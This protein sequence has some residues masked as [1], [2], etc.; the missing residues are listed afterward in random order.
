MNPG[1]GCG[2]CEACL[3]GADNLCR[4]YK[5]LGE[6]TDG[7]YAELVSV[8]LRN[9]LPKPE[10]MDFVQ[11]A[12]FPLVFLTAYHMLV[13]KAA[14]RPGETVLVL[15]A[16]SG[17]GVAAIQIAK[18]FD[19]NVVV[20]VGSEAKLEESRGTGGGLEQRTVAPRT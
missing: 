2:R 7:G 1:F 10:R 8:P 9:V 13:T 5:I 16:G 18:A 4:Q 6:H 15:G 11:A 3:T 20:S 14:L 19:V 12:S 17:V